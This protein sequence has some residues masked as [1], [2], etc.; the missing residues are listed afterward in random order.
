MGRRGDQLDEFLSYLDQSLVKI[1]GLCSSTH[2]GQ[3][4]SFKKALLF[5]FIDNL[6]TLAYPGPKSSACK[7][8]RLLSD[9]GHWQEIDH[10]STPHLCRWIELNPEGLTPRGS[11]VIREK[12]QAWESGHLIPIS[13]DH[14][15]ASI[16]RHVQPKGV[17]TVAALK[18]MTHFSLLWN[19]RHNLLHRFMPIG[20]NLE[21]PD[22]TSPYY[23][24]LSSMANLPGQSEGRL[25]WQLIYPTGFLFRL[26]RACLAGVTEELNGNAFDVGAHYRAG[27]YLLE[28]LN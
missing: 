20:V 1:E 5:A 24:S 11:Q 18:K 26:A 22:D 9:Y 3:C 13:F 4:R 27:L 8:R 17:N 19:Q 12:V 2:D 7:V 23:I 14:D 15:L 25:F 6:S 21:F 28:E 16:E 10:V